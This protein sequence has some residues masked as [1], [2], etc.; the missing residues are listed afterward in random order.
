M[1]LELGAQFTLMTSK[2]G[3]ANSKVSLLEAQ[4]VGKE[5]HRKPHNLVKTAVSAS[6][7]LKVTNQP[8]PSVCNKK[9]ILQKM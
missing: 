2:I 6:T 3:C 7:V 1:A 4:Q 5:D 8:L 9:A